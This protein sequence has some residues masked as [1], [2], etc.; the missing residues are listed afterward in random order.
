MIIDGLDQ[1]PNMMKSTPPGWRLF[2][3]EPQSRGN[4]L[5]VVASYVVDQP[6]GGTLP[7]T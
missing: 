3:R 4:F 7:H 1:I 5:K 2:N 6:E